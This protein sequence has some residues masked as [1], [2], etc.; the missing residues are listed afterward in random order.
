MTHETKHLCR[1]LLKEIHL[2]RVCRWR[3]KV[4]AAGS[5][6]NIFFLSIGTGSR[7]SLGSSRGDNSKLDSRL[8]SVQGTSLSKVHR[9]SSTYSGWSNVLHVAWYRISSL[10]S[11]VRKFSG[12]RH[13]SITLS[14]QLT[15]SL[16][17][18]TI[19]SS[20]PHM[21]CE[22]HSGS[23]DSSPASLFPSKRNIS[24]K[25]NSRP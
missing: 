5:R 3:C 14:V 19:L 13:C 16:S 21:L 1:F 22:C 2:E 23:L 4:T 6:F 7:Q 20:R 25:D 24:S 8:P 11:V 12:W 15:A 18:E 10:Y 17:F 9:V